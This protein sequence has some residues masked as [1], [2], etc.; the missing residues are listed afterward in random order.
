MPP[1]TAKYR[2]K[3]LNQKLMF[4]ANDLASLIGRVSR[5]DAQ[6]PDPRRDLDI[7]CGYPKNPSPSDYIEMFRTDGLANRCVSML[8]NESFGVQPVIYESEGAD[9]TGMEE[10]LQGLMDD[11]F[12]NPIQFMHK[13][14][15]ESRK[16]RFGIILIGFDDG[17]P[18]SEPVAGVDKN[19]FPEPRSPDA[20]PI[21]CIYMRA[22]NEK[23]VYIKSA[24]SDP[25][26]RRFG[27]PTSYNVTIAT[28]YNG[29][30]GFTEVGT[31]Q[32]VEVHW[33]R[34][35]HIAEGGE[36]FGKPVLED[37]Y[38]RILDVQKI[39]GSSAEMFY[40]GGFAPLAL[41]MDPRVLELKD[42]TFNLQS[43]DKDIQR[44]LN[45]LQRVLTLVGFSAKSLAPQ[46]SDPNP[47]LTSQLQLIAIAL[48]SPLRI[49][50]GAESGQLASAQDVKNW[51]RRLK[52]N[53]EGF[54]QNYV[55]RPL[56]NRLIY[57]GA[58]R[59]PANFDLEKKI[60]PAYKVFWPDVNIPDE[61]EK[62]QNADR[63]AAALMKYTMSG[64]FKIMQ[65]STFFRKILQ[66][67]ED[68]VQTMMDDLK[69]A[70]EIDYD[71]LLEQTGKGGAA[72]SG[73]KGSSPSD[74]PKGGVT[75]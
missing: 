7:E 2:P 55:V 47:H 67:S 22:F 43:L 64:A 63:L 71:K 15:L 8:A 4:T 23:N 27:K 75:D 10:D 16:A 54:L 42:F 38:K 9:Q 30:N 6:S 50:M 69:K 26:C 44:F 32:D 70:P 31:T 3:K 40:K 46:V 20:K 74:P 73:S 60:A 34:V 39:A 13:G 37:I 58:I 56:I 14:Y 12:T 35:I 61:A 41:E 72:D 33:T 36:V 11:P 21:K 25:T 1:P 24:E 65:I 19:D 17:K 5:L 29:N 48:N 59:P 62:S 18:L 53:Q 45:G 57:V 68:E 51:N 28:E 49:L 66:F 52:L